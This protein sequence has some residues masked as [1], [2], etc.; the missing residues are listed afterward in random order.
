MKTSYKTRKR[1][2]LKR[3]EYSKRVKQMHNEAAK[4][5]YAKFIAHPNYITDKDSK[6]LIKD[7]EYLIKMIRKIQS[8]FLENIR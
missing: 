2:R 4:K 1:D 5:W 3:A 6:K 7:P 8:E